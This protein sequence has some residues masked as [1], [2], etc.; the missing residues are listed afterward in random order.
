M[1]RDLFAVF[2]F[3]VSLEVGTKGK[4]IYFVNYH[5][6]KKGTCI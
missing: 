1:N 5:C 2:H 6:C 3:I 4:F